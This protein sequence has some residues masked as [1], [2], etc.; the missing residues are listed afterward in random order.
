VTP[1]VRKR[2]TR[3]QKTNEASR[4]GDCC[5]SPSLLPFPPRK[6]HCVRKPLCGVTTKNN[7]KDTF[8]TCDPPKN[9]KI[10][11]TQ[12]INTERFVKDNCVAKNKKITT[13][14]NT[15]NHT[16]RCVTDTRVKTKNKRITTTKNNN[17]DTERCVT[18]TRVKTKNKRISTTKN[19]NN[20]TERCVNDTRATTK[21]K[22]ITTT[23]N[24]NN[25]TERCVNDTRATTKNRRIAT[26]TV[27]TSSGSLTGPSPS[28]WVC[29]VST[30]AAV[31]R[32]A[33]PFAA[34][35]GDGESVAF[36][37]SLE[38]SEVADRAG[39]VGTVRIT[40]NSIPRGTLVSFGFRVAMNISIAAPGNAANHWVVGAVRLATSRDAL[41][42]TVQSSNTVPWSLVVLT[43][44]ASGWLD[45]SVS[46]LADEMLD[47]VIT[48]L[49]DGAEILE[50]SISV[51]APGVPRVYVEEIAAVGRALQVASAVA[52]V[53]SGSALGRMMATRSMVLCDADSAVGGGVLDLKLEICGV[54]GV[55]SVVARSAIVSNLIFVAVVASALLLLAALWAVLTH[56]RILQGTSVLCMPTSL[57]PALVAVIPSTASSATL[58][59][60]RLGDSECI[61]ADVV[62]GIVGLNLAALPAI[63]FLLL[64]ALRANRWMPIVRDEGA[65][66]AFH[67]WMAMLRRILRRRW[68]WTTPEGHRTGGM[69]RAWP[70]LLE[71]REL[72]YGAL[73]NGVLFAL[74]IVSVISG[75]T[76]SSAQCRAWSLVALLLLMAQLA[77]VVIMKPLTTT[78]S[79]HSAVYTVSLTC[80][81]VL[82]QLMFVWTVDSLW[83]VD[84]AAACSLAVLGLSLVTMVLNVVQLIAAVHRRI[85][86]LFKLRKS[87]A[88]ASQLYVGPDHESKLVD[89]DT[90]VS[91][92]LHASPLMVAEDSD[93]T[94]LQSPDDDDGLFWN[95][96]G[97]AVGTALVEELSDISRTD[98]RRW[99]WN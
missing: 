95:S 69:V 91:V 4:G 48:M 44:S 73:D 79:Q 23:K 98:E 67:P 94:F 84:A 20:D 10:N 65:L 36:L 17:N 39:L 11:T 3:S 88:R 77:A 27:G 54:S 50:V 93:N 33:P 19:N 8:T 32:L 5:F 6:T 71:Y 86:L 30:G 92:E 37:V 60:A 15:T 29:N 16:E 80:L 62:L 89:D 51:P 72:R 74:S 42:W 14:N 68:E 53:S 21:N 63:G 46:M 82:A 38:P 58:L 57:S 47:F 49:C 7:D 41:N 99:N 28:Q 26:N 55:T 43:T 59:L 34:S 35:V 31:V 70:V 81:G 1:T 25:D 45:A 61:T 66:V 85:V 76:G 56:T 18:D 90:P 52:S 22:R 96:D 64:W 40:T 87:H 83:L 13:T 12:T 78:F 75:L 9:K 2:G 24:N 97:A